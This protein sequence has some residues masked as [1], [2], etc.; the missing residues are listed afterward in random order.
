MGVGG[1]MMAAPAA[2]QYLCAEVLPL[3]PLVTAVGGVLLVGA[4]IMPC[5]TARPTPVLQA[6]LLSLSFNNTI[7]VSRNGV[8]V[9]NPQWRDGLGAAH[10]VVYQRSEV[11]AAYVD[12]VVDITQSV[13]QPATGTLRSSLGVLQLEC[14][15]CPLSVG[16]HTCRVKISNLPS[17][18]EAFQATTSAWVLD[19]ASS[20]NL[21]QAAL[22]IYVILNAPGPSFNGVVWAEA[23]DFLCGP[24][25]VRGCAGE[26]LAV[27]TITRYCHS[28]HGLTYESAN[29]Y[30]YVVKGG[31][32]C[33]EAYIL[34]TDP[35][36]NCYDQASA[37]QVLG[38][39]IGCDVQFRYLRAFGFIN[40]TNLMGVPDCNNPGYRLTGET[41]RLDNLSL[42]TPFV[43][44]A[45]CVLNGLV[46]DACI[47]PAVG[48]MTIE[49]Y[50]A[51]AIDDSVPREA[52]HRPRVNKAERFDGVLER[53]T[54]E[55]VENGAVTVLDRG[56]AGQ[57]P[58]RALSTEIERAGVR[59][60]LK[61]LVS[62]YN[63][64]AV[65]AL[66]PNRE[67]VDIEQV[68]EERFVDRLRREPLL[69]PAAAVRQ[70]IEDGSDVDEALAHLNRRTGQAVGKDQL[71]RQERQNGELEERKERD[72]GNVA[73]DKQIADRRSYVQADFGTAED[74]DRMQREN[75]YQIYDY[76]DHDL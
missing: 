48:Q 7:R 4:A 17:V 11:A 65:S 26:I 44:H 64:C 6:Q 50:L 12:A 43:D 60:R 18:I 70:W 33:L 8:E 16:R 45:C 61:Q 38:H 28:E 39:A 52:Y 34:R 3:A 76:D 69:A 40:L 53:A 19:G 23:L 29:H 13:A 2:Y 72:R 37:V 41:A 24:V 74:Y 63:Q 27:Q 67:T 9:V 59:D 10:P 51:T 20:C 1:F 21:G 22:Q 54:V 73:R 68:L 35:S 57:V 49:R 75:G 32:F 71:L 56:P 25:G 30:A 15:R 31:R 36:A 5:A 66:R 42:R 46:F 47:G 55:H 14:P 62:A 58:R